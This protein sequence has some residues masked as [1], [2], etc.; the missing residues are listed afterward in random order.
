M[1]ASEAEN[2]PIDSPIPPDRVPLNFQEDGY[3]DSSPLVFENLPP[4]QIGPPNQPAVE[5]QID[6][7]EVGDKAVAA[8]WEFGG[9]YLHKMG[10]F[11]KGMGRETIIENLFPALYYIGIP[12]FILLFIGD[13]IRK[14]F[15]GDNTQGLWKK[16]LIITLILV[17]I[18][19]WFRSKG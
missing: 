8:G 3:V 16:I 10:A 1:S 2:L 15:N 18:I 5:A 9:Q 6:T 11:W 19:L 4:D 14:K 12:L 7:F 17:G 13:F